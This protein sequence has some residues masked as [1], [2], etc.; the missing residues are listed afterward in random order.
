MVLC[1]GGGIRGVGGADGVPQHYRGVGVGGA[2]SVP[3]AIT[4]VVVVPPL[5][6]SP[7]F[8]W[9]WWCPSC[10]RCDVPAAT[11]AAIA[12]IFVVMSL[13]LLSPL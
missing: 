5:L 3:T 8:W 2:G 1:C 13:L 12:V 9:W 6:L 11:V 10:N 7:L 4:V